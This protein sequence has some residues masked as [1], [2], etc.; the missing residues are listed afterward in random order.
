MPPIL[1][2]VVCD[3]VENKKATLFLRLGSVKRACKR[4]IKENPRRFENLL[5]GETIQ[6]NLNWLY[7][8]CRWLKLAIKKLTDIDPI[9]HEDI[10]LRIRELYDSVVWYNWER[11]TPTTPPA[12]PSAAPPTAPPAAPGHRVTYVPASTLVFALVRGRARRSLTRE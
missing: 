6:S 1:S 9:N 2:K 11:E 8:Q 4:Q 3:T 5:T 12:A 7:T 10:F